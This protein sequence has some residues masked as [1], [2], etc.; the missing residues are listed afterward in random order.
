[1]SKLRVVSILCVC[2]VVVAFGQTNHAAF[3]RISSPANAWIT[4]FDPMAGTISWSNDVAGMTNQLKRAYVLNGVSNWV[5]FVQ[6]ATT[7]GNMTG[8]ERIIDLDPP[9]GMVLIPGGMNC[10]TNPLASGEFY[11]PPTYTSNYS[12]VV[13]AFY[14][15]TTEVTKA[16]WDVV[17]NWATNNAYSF[18]YDGYMVTT[19]TVTWYDSVK[20]CNARSEMEGRT[21][22]YTFGG[23][24]YRAG[25]NE[26]DCNFNVNGYRLPSDAEWEYAARSGLNSKRFPW[27][28]TITHNQA[29][30][31]SSS[32]HPYDI[33]L[34]RGYHPAYGGESSP[35]ASFAPNGYGLYDMAG[36]LPEWCNDWFPDLEG[37]YRVF[38]DGNFSIE[39]D[40]CRVGARVNGDPMDY[41]YCSFRA[42]RSA[43]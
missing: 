10:G 43:E 16:Q 15:D 41:G 8:T 30:Y 14:M 12:L 38:R 37:S 11:W 7:N 2:V 29:N 17:Y 24:I 5:D 26:P 28:D 22:C 20:W 36:N 13:E 3:F 39:A 32:S 23:N 31:Y 19:L 27:G 35:P 6:L 34:T 4:D 33:S 9:E 42:V 18:D 1:M 21:P 25:L 40:N